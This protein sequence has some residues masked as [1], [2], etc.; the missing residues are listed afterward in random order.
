TGSVWHRPVVAETAKD[1]LAKRQAQAAVALLQLG[2]PE[3]VWPL[4]E[5]RPDPRLR[6]FLIHRLAP[7][8]TDPQGLLRRLEE[9]R[10]VS[11]RRA[12]LLALGAYSV[13]RLGAAR[14][15]WGTRL[16][17]WYREEPDAGLH[18]A[19]E[20]LLRRWGEGDAVAKAEKEMACKEAQRK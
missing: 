13:E 20:W 10:E 12:L 6:S 14:E 8:A 3:K 9:E 2:A 7:L 1:A 17:Q 15:R 16:R 18:G 19:V 5:H 11:R 4:L